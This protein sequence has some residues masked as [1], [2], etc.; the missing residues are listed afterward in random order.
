[1]KQKQVIRNTVT[2][3]IA[4]FVVVGAMA[5]LSGWFRT[6]KIQP[7]SVSA[8]ETTSRPSATAP[9][10]LVQK[11][12]RTRFGPVVGSLQAEV[13]TTIS[14]RLV[15][16][17]LEMRVNAGDRVKKG[18]VLVL[19]DDAAPKSRVAQA[20]EALRAAQASEDLAQLEVSRLTP[21]AAQ[22][23]AS[24]N[25][26]DEWKSK[27]NMAKADVARSNEAIREA[28]AVLADA[29]IVSPIDGIVIDRQAE[30]GEQASPGRPLL[31]LYD[32]SRLRMEANVREGYLGRLSL[33]QKIDVTIETLNQHRPGTVTQIVPAADPTSRTFLVKVTLDDSSNLY[34]GMYA[35]MNVPLDAHEQLEIPLRAVRRIGQ[36]DLVDL[37]VN[38]QTQRR[39]VRLGQVADDHV[40]V[41]AGLSEGD[42]VVLE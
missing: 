31:T 30:P 1:M 23:A 24:T 3:V 17:I 2:I 16:N 29:K 36:L 4:V 40:E 13:R 39:A 27:L 37:I 5:W 42:R 9:S 38:G 25:E 34:P 10:A 19:L 8:A 26:L 11:V 28:E 7:G 33:G 35:R 18:D 6:D 21:L 12:S 14:S 20:R 32:P 15:A 41:L 22:N